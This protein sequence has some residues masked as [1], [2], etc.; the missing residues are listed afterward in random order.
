[1]GSG[2]GRY[3][4]LSLESRAIGT[5]NRFRVDEASNRIIILFFNFKKENLHVETHYFDTGLQSN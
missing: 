5:E 1:V 2:H 3:L 4:Q